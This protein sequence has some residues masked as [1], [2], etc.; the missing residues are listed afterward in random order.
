MAGSSPEPFE[1]VVRGRLVLPEG[2]I[3]EGDLGIIG[4]R[5]AALA[6][7]GGLVAAEVVDAGTSLVLPGMVDV[8][9]HTGSEATEGIGRATRAAAAGGVTTVVDMPFDARGPLVD[10]E[11][12]QAKALAIA[13]EAVVDVALYGTVPASGDVQGVEPLARAG[14]VAFKLSTFETHPTR[15]PR[16][17]S[18]TI[19]RTLELV[20]RLGSL[21]AFHCEDDE[22]IRGLLAELQRRDGADRRA[23]A[24]SRP[25][26]AE[27]ASIAAVLE[28]A[29]ATGAAIHVCHVSTGRGVALVA[30]ARREGVD[31]TA[32]TCPHY[33]L[34]GETEL[35]RQG[36]RAKVN[37]PL[38]PEDDVEALWSALADGDL[39]LV[40]SDHVGW[41]PAAKDV[42]PV[43]HAA[44]GVPGVELTL[45]LLFSEGAVARGLPLR[46]FVELT[47]EAPARRYG[48]WPRKGALV[49]GADA[50]LVVFD[51]QARWRVDDAGMHAAAGWSP[52][53]GRPVTG[54]IAMTFGRGDLV[55]DGRRPVGPLGRGRMLTRSPDA[56]R[57]G[58]IAAALPAVARQTPR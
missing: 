50:D 10:L 12:L 18:H 30:R 41:L 51:E 32:E 42:E 57:E 28:L 56:S 48:L 52:Y 27:A 11:R 20:R 25:P 55:Y 39:D 46:R 19:V 53:H 8:H 7:R 47:A 4:G 43:L 37:P 31:V 34:L 29:A 33:L 44:A 40:S 17:N 14:V 23:H 49:V 3:R 2:E 45:P 15:F 26:A 58:K 16:S 1:L 24:G 5:I 22:L 36:G 35:E 38:R 9:V 13:R 6:A 54:R 21:A